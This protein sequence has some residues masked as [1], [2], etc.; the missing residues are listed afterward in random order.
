MKRYITGVW[1]R[2]SDG[3]LEYWEG[4]PPLKIGDRSMTDQA[5]QS[6]LNP[7]WLWVTRSVNRL[8]DRWRL[9][10]CKLLKLCNKLQSVYQPP[11]KGGIPAVLIPPLGWFRLN[12]KRR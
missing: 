4:E 10:A 8:N 12:R 3:E 7:L 5:Y 2:W 9:V 1:T 11:L 6:G